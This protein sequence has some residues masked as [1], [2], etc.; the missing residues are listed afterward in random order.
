MK[1]KI[2]GNTGLF[3][4]ELCLGTMTF[5]G[6]G[7]WTQIGALQQSA[8]NEIVKK[9]VDS[10]IN[11]ID[12]ANVYSEGEAEKILGQSIKDLGLKRDDLIIATKV[13]GKTGEGPNHIG[14]TR[15]HIFN[16]VNESLLRLQ[17]DYI[18]LYQIHG[19]DP[20][21]PLE[22]TLSALNDLV[23]TGIVRYIGCSNLMAWHIMKSMAISEK[24][25]WAHFVSLQAY[26]TIAGRDLER[27]IVP[28]L[29]D[30]HLGLMVWS[31][32]AGGLLSGKYKKDIKGPEG[33]R[34]ASFN[35]PPVNLDR[36]Y[37][38]IDAMAAIGKSHGVSVARVALAWILSKQ[39]VTTV[40]IGAKNP[41]QLED[42]IEATELSLSEKELKK[43]DE[44]SELPQ[45]YPGWM[46]NRQGSDRLN[47]LKK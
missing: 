31:P 34:R 10:G 38:I 16:Q 41:E 44:I 25:N 26:Y 28:L 13:R 6:K 39:F 24:N 32:L 33:S 8:A 7:M 12:T 42:N 37:P 20:F 11:F 43:L 5:G 9:S 15:H 21:T 23:R 46:I 45:E 30:Q 36:A 40:I 27:E 17:T 19:F 4:S 3:V 14:L 47:I 22:E 18:D 35:F 1:Y 2:L 29:N